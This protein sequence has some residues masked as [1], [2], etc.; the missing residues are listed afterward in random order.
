[1]VGNVPQTTNV[2]TLV[3]GFNMTALH[4]PV[5]TNL[6]GSLANY[7]GVSDPNGNNNDILFSWVPNT[8]GYL[9][10][11]YYNAADAASWLGGTS[12]G[13]YDSGGNLNNFA[14][15]VGAG[16]FIQRLT[17]QTTTWTNVFNFSN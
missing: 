16:F 3:P 15:N 2:T 17:G 14:P 9:I 6:V 7:T 11:Y 8:Q 5:V 10:L 12:A 13:F 1:M 4:S